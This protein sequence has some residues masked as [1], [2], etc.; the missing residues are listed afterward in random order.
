MQSRFRSKE[1]EAWKEKN[2]FHQEHSAESRWTSPLAVAYY[3]ATAKLLIHL[4]TNGQ[5]GYFRDE[6]YYLARGDHLDWGYVDQAPLAPWLARLSRVLLGDSL[7]ALRFLPAVA[8]ATKVLLTGLM[9]HEFGG[10]HFAVMLACLCVLVAPGYLGIDTL[11]SVN[12]FEPLFWMGCAYCVIL[13]I[14]RD[15][16]RAWLWFGLLAGLGLENKHSMLFFGFGLFIGLLLTSARR[17]LADKWLWIGSAVAFALFLPNLLWQYQHDWPTLEVLR[18]VQRTGKNVVLSPSAYIAQQVLLLLPLTAPVWIAGLW[19]F[20]FDRRGVRYRTLGIAY[21]VVLVLMIALTGKNYYLLPAYPMLFAGGA[22]LWEQI[23]QQRRALWWL[24]VV[25]PVLV[26][27]SGLVIAPLALPFLSV[28]TYLRYQQMLG[29]KPLRTE[30]GHAS[31]LPQVFSDMFGWPEMVETVAHVYHALPP[32][33]RSKAAILA[34]NFGEAGAI[35]FFGPRYGLPKAISPHQNYYLWEPRD[36]TGEI[37]IVLGWGREA[38]G[39]YCSSVETA[40]KVHHPY[41]M[42]TEHYTIF[43]CR[44]LKHPLREVWPQWKHWN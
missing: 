9:V 4:L 1:F 18:N 36:Y 25:F 14:N 5:Y 34:R 22:V 28:E 37:M 26:L 10:R 20:F 21:V 41:A 43:I 42:A 31:P 8:G 40:G 19:F 6:F 33:E 12:A 7:S 3:F 44:G 30:V 29:V 11:F 35:D 32:D 24:Q 13:A 23:L 16:P 27:I 38:V 2:S 39:E 17:F 15:D